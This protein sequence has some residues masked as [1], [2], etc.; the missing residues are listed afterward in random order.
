M[1]SVGATF[2]NYRIEAP[3]GS[4]GTGQIYRAVHVHLNRPV[5]LKILHPQYA[6]DP[7]FQARFLQE[8]RA[9]AAL[10]HPNIVEILDFGEE[11]GHFYL[12]MEL[13][14][15][16]SVRTLL[17]A[18]PAAQHALDLP[19]ALDLIC[20][21]ADGLRFA[22]RHGMV[23]RDVKPDNLL[24][25]E[26]EQGGYTVKVTD[27]GL[28]R[29]A[30]GGVQTLDG[31]TMGTPAY[32]SPEQCRGVDLDGRSDLYSLGVTLYELTTGSLPF[33]V[34]TISDAVFKHVHTPVPPPRGVR[35][36]LPVELEQIILRCLAKD[37]AERFASAEEL[38]AALDKVRATLAPLTVVPPEQA[39]KLET[40]SGV[41]VLPRQETAL[42]T[43]G[44]AAVVPVTLANLGGAEARARLVVDGVPAE[45]LTVPGE[46]LLGPRAQRDASI[47]VLVPRATGT[48]AGDY[49]VRLRAVGADGQE[50]GSAAM[51]WTVQPFGSGNLELSAERGGWR[52]TLTNAG[53]QRT[54]FGLHA[55]D[56]REL[57]EYT[58]SPPSLDL[59]AGARG[60]A[61]LRIRPRKERPSGPTL[62]QVEARSGG[63][64]P[65]VALGTYRPGGRGFGIWRW[66]IA[67]AA[68]V[69]VVG[70][71]V[72]LIVL[73]AAG[74]DR[75]TPATVALIPS[76]TATSA[77][78]VAA[79]P[80]ATLAP[81]TATSTT[82]PQPTA[83]T[84]AVVVPTAT[85]PPTATPTPT[86]TPTATP[87]PPPLA[88]YPAGMR[89]WR[90]ANADFSE[91]QLAGVVPALIGTLQLDPVAATPL[92]DVAGRY[93]GDDY[94]Q[95]DALS[96]EIVPEQP[97]T[98]LVASWNAS[99]PLGT[100]IEVLVSARIGERWTAEYSLGIWAEDNASGIRKSVAGQGDADATVDVDT[101]VLYNPA[102]AYR[103]RVRFLRFSGDGVPLLT[104]VAAVTYPAPANPSTLEPGDPARW[105]RTLPVP[106]CSSSHT[107]RFDSSG[108]S[109]AMVLAYWDNAPD[110]CAT[111]VPAAAEG[112][113]DAVYGGTG[114]W[115]F[116]TAYAAA[117]HPTF[118]AYVSRFDGLA[119]AERWIEA[120]VPLI[121][122]F[123]YSSGALPGAPVDSSVGRLAVLVGF[124]ENGDVVINEPG[125]A[126]DGAPPLTYPREA[127]ER[128]WLSSSGGIAYLIY[129][130]GTRI[131]SDE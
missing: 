40:P 55:F 26:R 3:L 29:L 4:G 77:V 120:G 28:A 97:F 23:H 69:L 32:M 88:R 93:F 108:T 127:F 52:L 31:T 116:A 5:A 87:T 41:R 65:L 68:A 38:R 54:S 24:L 102:D 49:P 39:T 99:T 12:V 48:A 44:V 114:N 84:A 18:R 105:G 56:D 107:P 20:Q 98:R 2:G 11:G 122:S 91:W 70:L 17:A 101:L 61:M 126:S 27:F 121:V 63:N 45:W 6:A 66:V 83:T 51:R 47:G 30:E 89:V 80:T 125:V 103:L 123:G 1:H 94:L 43:P 25:W 78:G 21:A 60:T 100:A 71:V 58:I 10:R 53:N 82:P 72:V 76:P 16:G 37:P 118:E 13:V 50:L 75:D 57:L 95:G 109:L 14:S 85:P 86:F 59:A 110:A 8:A 131:P 117:T 7:G 15:G 81:P 129:P 106:S 90:A 36:D 92:S 111:R 124:T 67:S 64:P 113:Y 22:H 33:Q 73:L 62:F 115:P 112:V 34:R 130:T 9:A 74:G 96:P 42:L 46:L 79:E 119:E 19:L 35:P 128:A 104:N